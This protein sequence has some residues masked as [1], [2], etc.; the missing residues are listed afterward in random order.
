MRGGTH[1]GHITTGETAP[2]I[3]EWRIV[4]IGGADRHLVGHVY[5]HPLLREGARAITSR[6]IWIDE[7]AAA[8]RTA[9]RYYHLGRKA[10]GSLPD[11]WARWLDIY[12]ALAWGAQRTG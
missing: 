10:E 3:E 1:G 12:L 6:L 8:A 9:S 4:E 2:G 11:K 5:G 7:A